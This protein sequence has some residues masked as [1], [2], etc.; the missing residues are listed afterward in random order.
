MDPS[1]G[2]LSQL[3]LKEFETNWSSALLLIA[4]K[5]NFSP[6]NFKKS[7][8][9]RFY[10]L[11]KPHKSIL[12]Q[13]IFGALLYTILGLSIPIYIQKITD[14][15]LINGN[16][17]LLNLMSTLM[18]LLISIQALIGVKKQS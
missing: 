17:N 8:I 7:N 18:I 1:L 5:Y 10:E 13:S 3:S 12:F 9:N 11:I 2:H 14:H 6:A 16:K 4:P 15:V